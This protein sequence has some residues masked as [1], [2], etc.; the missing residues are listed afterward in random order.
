MK[1]D[2]SICL[3]AH[4]VELWERLYNSAVAAVGSYTWE[5]II[6]GP[7]DPPSSLMEKRNFKFFKDFGHPTRCAQIATTL[8][9]GE[10]MMWASDDGFFMPDSIKNCVDLHKQ[11]DKKDLIIV[12]YSEGNGHS[13]QMPPDDYWKAWTH[14][15]QRLPGIPEDFLCVPVGMYNLEYFRELGGW[16]CRF[17]HLNMCTHDLAFRAQRAGSKVRMSPGLVLNCDW[18]WHWEDSKPIQD[19]YKMNDAPLFT[20]LYSQDQSDRIKIDYFNWT[21]AASIW[22]R[23]FNK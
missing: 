6:V 23:R 16:D 7:N 12:R 10:L 9:E 21:S 11:N 20:D 8:A 18:S 14:A 4:R 3:P 1:Y 22:G 2:V 13:G 15:D 17:E 19:A 5:M